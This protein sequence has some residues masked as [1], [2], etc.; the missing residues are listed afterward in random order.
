VVVKGVALCARYG[1][2]P[3]DVPISDVDL[4]ITTRSWWRLRAELLRSEHEAL[5]VDSPFYAN[6]VLELAGHLVDV[7]ATCGP[8]FLTGLRVEG[9]LRRAELASLP[10]AEPFL[11]PCTTDHALLLTI[12]LFKDGLTS[13]SKTARTNALRI[14]EEVGFEREAYVARARATSMQ[15]LAGTV[16]RWLAPQSPEWTAIAEALGPV[17]RPLYDRVLASTLPRPASYAA[18]LVRRLA[19]D[20]WRDRAL[21]L[22]AATGLVLSGGAAPPRPASPA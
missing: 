14:V 5:V 8:P 22:S 11:V 21:A 1:W 9:L 3:A 6:L 17:S 4:R 15:T 19:S 13:T 20:R 7:E 18:R 16:A 2:D 10:G 12:N